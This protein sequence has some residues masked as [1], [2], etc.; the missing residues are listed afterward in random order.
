MKKELSRERQGKEKKKGER[1]GTG[2][3]GEAREESPLV[4]HPGSP[5]TRSP[6]LAPHPSNHPLSLIDTPSTSS[7][8]AASTIFSLS[9]QRIPSE[10]TKN[11][12]WNAK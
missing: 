12:K 10:K 3:I 5:P 9:I 2:N 1:K 11:Y 6:P 4:H 8:P 7:S